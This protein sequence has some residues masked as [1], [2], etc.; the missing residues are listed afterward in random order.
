MTQ[1]R[2]AENLFLYPFFSV[3]WTVTVRFSECVFIC[4]FSRYLYFS[5]SFTAVA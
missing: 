4:Y 5:H 2:E 3:A 1:G